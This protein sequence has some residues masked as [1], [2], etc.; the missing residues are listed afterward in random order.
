MNW[1]NWHNI[2]IAYKYVTLVNML[3]K[4]IIYIP[5]FRDRQSCILLPIWN[6]YSIFV[7]DCAHNLDDFISMDPKRGV[8]TVY[9]LQDFV[10]RFYKNM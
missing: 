10:R 7:S 6:I 5:L 2:L 4:G 3:A 8:G 9:N 1:L